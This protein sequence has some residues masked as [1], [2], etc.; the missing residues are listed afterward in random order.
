M[1]TAY[2]SVERFRRMCKVANEF[3]NKEYVKDLDIH[4]EY[5]RA[6]RVTLYKNSFIGSVRE[7]LKKP[8]YSEDVLTEMYPLSWS[9]LGGKYDVGTISLDRYWR[10]SNAEGR[11]QDVE[12]KYNKD[13]D[14]LLDYQTLIVGAV[15]GK[16]CVSDSDV[17]W[18]YVH[19]YTEKI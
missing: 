18:F 11:R 9:E 16:V 3:I 12:D 5:I 1:A 2:I 13:Q 14:K 17:H 10:I 19:G 6:K 8:V 7:F 15:D 4:K